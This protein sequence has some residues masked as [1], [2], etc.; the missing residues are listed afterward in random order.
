MNSRAVAARILHAVL[1]QGQSLDTA[2]EHHLSH[3]NANDHAFIQALSYGVLRHW[4]QA[5]VMLRVLLHKPLQDGNEVVRTL[6][7]AG[8]HELTQMRTATYA[9]V[10]QTVEATQDLHAHWARGL[11]NAIL[12]NAQRRQDDLIAAIQQDPEAQ[13]AHPRWLQQQLQRDWPEHWASIIAANNRQA[14]LVLRCNTRQTTRDAYIYKLAQAG[15]T[16]QATPFATDGI[17]LTQACDVQQLPGFAQGEVSVQDAAAQLVAPILDPQPGER[18]LDACAAPGGKTLHLLERQ[19]R[20]AELVAIDNVADR[21]THVRENLQ[22]A[23]LTATL[24][25][26]DA[27]QPGPWWDKQAF[28]RIL[29]DAPCSATGVIRRHPDIKVHRRASDIPVL[30]RQQQQILDALWPL[31]KPGGILL[32]TTCSVLVQEND[33]QLDSFLLRHADAAGVAISAEWGHATTHG[34]QILPGEYDMDGFYY[35]RLAKHV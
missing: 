35:A 25:C 7:L 33:A 27:T 24:H 5:E 4:P 12:R 8:L 13:Y 10:S 32:Y 9:A 29:V 14:P 30:A 2:L 34:R 28:D 20:M 16:G 23:G 22:R 15:L 1:D 26:A 6:L 3:A 17:V 11:V 31:L 18:I 19:P 21:V